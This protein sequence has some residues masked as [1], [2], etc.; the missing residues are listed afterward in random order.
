[1]SPRW[2]LQNEEREKI[3]TI[4]S[5][6]TIHYNVTWWVTGK[7]SVIIALI[8]D[9]DAHFFFLKKEAKFGLNPPMP[10]TDLNGRW[11]M[12]GSVQSVGMSTCWTARPEATL[13][14]GLPHLSSTRAEDTERNRSV[15][16]ASDFSFTHTH[17]M[18]G[19]GLLLT[20]S[21]NCQLVYVGY[22]GMA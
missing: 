3:V 14:R 18:E 20:S 8:I 10:N 7:S 5:I 13:S 4:N 9:S 1:M 19:V 16:D 11:T 2:Q 6:K 22:N 12:S 17:A 15:H 21:E